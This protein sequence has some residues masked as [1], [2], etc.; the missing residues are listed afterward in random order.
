MTC[1]YFIIFIIIIII[2]IIISISIISI[3]SYYFPH[4]QSIFCST[5]SKTCLLS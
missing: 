5:I 3:H 2:I 1:F 4:L